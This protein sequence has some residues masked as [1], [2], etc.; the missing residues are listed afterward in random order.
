MSTVG[1]ATPSKFV[2]LDRMLLSFTSIFLLSHAVLYYVSMHTD[3]V[4]ETMLI[5]M[6]LLLVGAI[7]ATVVTARIG[8]L[9]FLSVLRQRWPISPALFTCA[10]LLAS[11]LFIG[12]AAVSYALDQFRFHVGKGFYVAEVEKSNSSPKFVVF[13]WAVVSSWRG[14][15]SIFSSSMKTTA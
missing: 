15:P 10:V 6:A 13:D 7:V 9:I 12:R 11:Y 1:S 14:A 3:G 5:N 4:L 8:I 2:T